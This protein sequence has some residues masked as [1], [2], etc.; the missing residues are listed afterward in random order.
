MSIKQ[1]SHR[2][3]SEKLSRRLLPPGRQSATSSF[4]QRIDEQRIPCLLDCFNTGMHAA[5]VGK[6]DLAPAHDFKQCAISVFGCSF[7]VHNLPVAQ[8]RGADVLARYHLHGTAAS[9]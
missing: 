2:R 9:R 8:V 3:G 6:F 5:V 4:F 7:C 1:E